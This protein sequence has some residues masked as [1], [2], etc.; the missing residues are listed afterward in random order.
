MLEP[1]CTIAPGSE[2]T[3]YVAVTLPPAY[4]R[5]VAGIAS[6]PLPYFLTAWRQP[7]H[8]QQSFPGSLYLSIR[9]ITW[10]TSQVISDSRPTDEET[11]IQTG[12]RWITC[13]GTGQNSDQMGPMP[14]I[15]NLQPKACIPPMSHPKQM[16][17]KHLLMTI[18]PVSHASGI[19]YPPRMGLYEK[20]DWK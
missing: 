8:P 9:V 13:P 2:R 18:M 7:Y 12:T 10:K 14:R 16:S 6:W 3:R 17:E 19:I 4:L 5:P 1:E 11:K 20:E 15:P